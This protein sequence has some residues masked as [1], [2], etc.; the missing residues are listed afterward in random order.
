MIISSDIAEG[1]LLSVPFCLCLQLDRK[2][3]GASVHRS[4]GNFKFF[5]AEAAA[6]EPALHTRRSVSQGGPQG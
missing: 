6:F 2:Q 4:P 1:R 3:R 5:E